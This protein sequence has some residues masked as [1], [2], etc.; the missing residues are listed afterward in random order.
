MRFNIVVIGINAK[1]SNSDNFQGS[2]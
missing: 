1:S 2:N